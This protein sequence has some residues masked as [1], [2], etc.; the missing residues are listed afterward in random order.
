MSPLTAPSCS[1]FKLVGIVFGLAIYNSTILDVHFPPVIYSY[2]L[3]PE[4]EPTF[5]DLRG[6]FPALAQG[7]QQV[8]DYPGEDVEEVF[9][10]SFAVS[11]EHF[12]SVDTHELV[13]GGAAIP[14]TRA[15]RAEYVARYT[16]WVLLDSVA[17][18]L[19]AFVGGF[20]LLA[21][22]DGFL[23]HLLPQELERIV[24]GYPH[25]NL[26]EL[27]RVTSYE[28]GFSADSPVVGWFWEVVAGMSTADQ[29]RLLSFATGSDRVPVGGFAEMEF[30]I[31]RQGEDSE[32]LPTSHTC[33]NVL[34][35]PEY[36]SL[37]K[38]RQKLEFAIQ[39]TE[40]FML[41]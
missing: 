22:R 29:H 32:A 7:L 1:E 6:A 35:L 38:L 4:Y 26:A 37:E 27:Q 3:N 2:L 40:G 19:R 10:L 18:S 21:K 33:F 41:I 23:Q 12:G 36:S 9:C 15:N 14:V 24:C 20:S 34:L 5:E 31:Q 11:V 8:L 16:R 13:P 30:V 39:Q 25:W 17:G 28:G